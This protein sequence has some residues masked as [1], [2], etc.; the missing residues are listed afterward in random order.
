MHIHHTTST[1]RFPCLDINKSYTGCI[2]TACQAAGCVF[3][4]KPAGRVI[5]RVPGFDCLHCGT[6]LV[7]PTGRQRYCGGTQKRTKTS[8][9]QKAAMQR[10]RARRLGGL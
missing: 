2:G 5:D 9:G 7:K 6:R 10:R 3:G 8:C 1:N 4:K